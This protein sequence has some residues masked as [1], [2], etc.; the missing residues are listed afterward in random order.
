LILDEFVFDMDIL[1][2]LILMSFQGL[3][4]E[5]NKSLLKAQEEF[6]TNVLYTNN[7]QMSDN[8]YNTFEA[9]SEII[10]YL[11]LKKKYNKSGKLILPYGG[12]RLK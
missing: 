7:P 3:C 2:K 1:E 12:T 5:E 9:N 8:A 11:F 10:F 6:L 4:L